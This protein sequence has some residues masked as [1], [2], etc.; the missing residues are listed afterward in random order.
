[1]TTL[2]Y[3]RR[4]RERHLIARLRASF[5]EVG[6]L[7]LW[8]ESREN[9]HRWRLQFELRGEAEQQTTTNSPSARPHLPVRIPIQPSNPPRV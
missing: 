4:L 5:T 7:E 1:V 3:G 2:R 9:P 6:T 8:F